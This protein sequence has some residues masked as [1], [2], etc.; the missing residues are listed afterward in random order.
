VVKVMVSSG[1]WSRLWS[2]VFSGQGCGQYRSEVKV[3]VNNGQ[4]SRLWSVDVRGQGCG[5]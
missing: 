5:Q 1:H 3:M 4:W 2:V